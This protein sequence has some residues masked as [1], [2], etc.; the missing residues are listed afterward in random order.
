MK[1]D[2][3]AE[4]SL[5]SKI[6][7]ISNQPRPQEL[8]IKNVTALIFA[9][10]S[11][12]NLFI[13]DSDGWAKESQTYTSWKNWKVTARDFKIEK[14]CV[15]K[16]LN[17]AQPNNTSQKTNL[18]ILSLAAKN[19]AELL[20]EKSDFYPMGITIA[21][22]FFA[23]LVIASGNNDRIR[24]IFGFISAVITVWFG[25]TRLTTRRQIAELKIIANVL[26]VAEKRVPPLQ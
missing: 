20:S 19:R 7:T 14:E 6:D 4:K 23:I 1:S 10:N 11:I 2:T 18:Q 17:L 8:T 15:D 22:A 13:N 16:I 5:D 25:F 9:R 24:F 3:S 12:S 21:I 26:D